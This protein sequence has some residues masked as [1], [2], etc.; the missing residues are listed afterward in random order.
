MKRTI[1]CI[2]LLLSFILVHSAPALAQNGSPPP[3]PFNHSQTLSERHTMLHDT[4]L[5][6]EAPPGEFVLL[7]ALVMRPL[8]LAALGVGLAGS[9]VILPF[10]AFTDSG[11]IVGES[12]IKKPFDYTF[13]RQLGDID[14]QVNR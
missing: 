13:R 12:L 6:E 14:M 3:S 8:G 11:S 2:I 10:T 5:E 9:I 7:D 1:T 4:I